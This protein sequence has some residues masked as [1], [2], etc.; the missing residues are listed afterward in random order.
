M[1]DVVISGAGPAGSQCAEVLAKAGYKVALIEKNTDWRKPCGGAVHSSVVDLYP[2]LKK[3]NKPKI[4][5]VVMHSA[6]YHKLEFKGSSK[7]YSIIMDRLELDNLMRTAAVEAG[8]ELFDRNTSFDFIRKDQKR[9]GIKTKTPNYHLEYHAKII[10]V[11]DGMSSKLALKSGIRSKWKNSE[12][13]VGKCAIMEGD[14]HLDEETVYVYFKPYQGYGWIFPL[15]RKQFNIGI[16]TFGKDNLNHNLHH[17]YNEFLDNP[18]VKKYIPGVN[19]KIVWSGAYSFPAEGVIEKGLYDDNLMLI[20]DAG[21]FVSPISGEGIQTAVISGKVAA[22]T[23]IKALQNEDYTKNSLKKYKSNLEIKDIIRNFK[24]KR[25]MINY[26][27]ENE[28]KNLNNMLKLAQE[29]PKFRTQI[30]NLFAFGEIPSKDLL[31]RIND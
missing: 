28:G 4:S 30:V 6:D 2:T 24:L 29:D 9:I 14:N 12:I 5:D 15:S 23:A 8:A 22:E 27:Y 21:G 18:N 16:F 31:A 25:S 17:I 19:Y 13:A 7:E 10:I 26:F 3:L 1:Y 11:A 20:G